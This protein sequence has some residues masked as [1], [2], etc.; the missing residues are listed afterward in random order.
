VNGVHD[1]GV[2]DPAQVDRG[3]R[4]VGVPELTLDD[5][6]RHAFARHLHSM[7]VS[8]LM[9]REAASDTRP[10]GSVVQLRPDSGWR[11]RR[12]RVGPRS[13]QN[14]APTGSVFRTASQG[15]SWVQAQRS[16]PTS[17]R[18]SPLPCYAGAGVM[19]NRGCW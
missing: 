10:G 14:R 13:T 3:D 9:R 4:E 2:I 19:P 17:R 11:P 18:L 12:P 5:E 8:E 15:S 16:I 1:L 6:Q 7:S